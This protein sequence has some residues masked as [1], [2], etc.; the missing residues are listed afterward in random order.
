MWLMIGFFQV[1]IIGFLVVVPF[2]GVFADGG[3]K[4]PYNGAKIEEAMFVR[5]V[6]MLGREQ[7]EY[8]TRLV[9]NAVWLVRSAKGEGVAVRRAERLIGV[10]L[11]LSPKNESAEVAVRSLENGDIPEMV[12]GVDY[13]GEVFA[14]LMM[15]RAGLLF[16]GGA[17]RDGVLG[18]CFLSLALELDPGNKV[19]RQRLADSA[20]EFGVL[21]WDWVMGREAR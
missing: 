19:L 15:M 9:A 12:K 1:C 3:L 6:S 14:R 17:E 21:N 13:Y 5:G 8:A 4:V 10:A 18:R 16:K 20:D 11:H 2:E 7:D